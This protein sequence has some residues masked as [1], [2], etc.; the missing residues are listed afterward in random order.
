MGETS[1]KGARGDTPADYDVFVAQAFGVSGGKVDRVYAAVCA[2]VKVR[3][4]YLV[5]LLVYTLTLT[6]TPQLYVA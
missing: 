2:A 1:S 3:P 6:P 5:L 4:T